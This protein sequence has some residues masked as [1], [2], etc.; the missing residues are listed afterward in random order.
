MRKYLPV[1]L[2]ISINAVP[3]LAHA[4]LESAMYSLRSQMSTVFLPAL[5]L[6]GIVIAGISMAMGHHNAKNHV[7]MAVV[8]AIVGFGADGIIDFV[9]RTFG[10]M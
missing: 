3:L 5:S 4:S 7:T 2:A 6:V 8:G 9:R 10:G 1:I